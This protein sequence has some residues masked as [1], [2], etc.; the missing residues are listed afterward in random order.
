[1]R[2][3]L[4]TILAAALAL[5][6]CSAADKPR[7]GDISLSGFLGQDAG[8]QPGAT[9]ATGAA[10]YVHIEPGIDLA[11]FTAVDLEPPQ[12]WISDAQRAKIGED[13]LA[14]LLTALN[15]S[16]RQALGAHWDL[17][18]RS[19]PDVLRIRLAICN[20]PPAGGELTAFSRLVPYSLIADQPVKASAS[21]FLNLDAVHAEVELL[22]GSQRLAAFADRLPGTGSLGTVFPS[23]A[24]VA[25]RCSAW[26]EQ[27]VHHL[28]DYGMVPT[29]G[30]PR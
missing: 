13:Q 5:P 9:G 1:M 26:G 17:T 20:P 14:Y 15:Q 22:D 7:G 12:A 19:A 6:A 8:L 4:V 3:R 29:R 28:T 18:D 25:G 27:L 2:A 21:N 11:R 16:L 24:D 30:G 10:N 23:W